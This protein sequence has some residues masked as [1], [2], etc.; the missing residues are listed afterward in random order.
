MKLNAG[1]VMF[2]ELEVSGSLGCMPVDYPR[3]IE[4]VRTRGGRLAELVTHRFPLAEIGA[5]FD[6]LRS[7]AVARSQ[8]D[9]VTQPGPALIRPIRS[10]TNPTARS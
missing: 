4:L 9:Q 1:R 3:V 2:R 7:R 10:G 5:A 8:P 6:A